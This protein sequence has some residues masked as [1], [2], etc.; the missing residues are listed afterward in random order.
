MR[1][2]L[3]KDYGVNPS[4]RICFWCGEDFGELALFG[5]SARKVFGTDE[6]PM[7]FVGGSE[8]CPACMKF[9]QDGYVTLRA[10]DLT[11]EEIESDGFLNYGSGSIDLDDNLSQVAKALHPIVWRIRREALE[12]VLSGIDTSRGFLMAPLGVI[13][14]LGFP[15]DQD[16]GGRQD[17]HEHGE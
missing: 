5:A 13:E 17:D 2:Y 16:D 11:E 3:S 7:N 9:A 1:L 15:M 14:A 6:A 8:P 12:R 4:V 10:L